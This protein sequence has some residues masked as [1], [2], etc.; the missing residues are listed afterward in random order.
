MYGRYRVLCE[1]REFLLGGMFAYMPDDENGPQMIYNLA[2]QSGPG[3]GA[4]L[5][6]IAT[7]VGAALTDAEDWGGRLGIPR[8]G[9]GLGGLRWKDVQGVLRT[10][11]GSRLHKH[12]ELIVVTLPE[13]KAE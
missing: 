3:G 10:V 12:A 9:C 2:T 1:K 7:S 11:A 4:S 8:I 13:G 6:A 5:G